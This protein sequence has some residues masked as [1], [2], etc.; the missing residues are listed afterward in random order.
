MLLTLVAFAFALGLLVTFHEWGHYSV[1]RLCG[2]PIVR[3]SVG[4]GPVLLRRV[5]RHG[6]EWALSAIPLGGYVKM[7]DD[8]P[9]GADAAT[10][11]LAF[12]HQPLTRRVAIVLA[13][14]LANLLLAALVYAF[15]G[16]WGTLQ[17]AAVLAAPAA[18]TPAAMAG[19]PA[20][21]ILTSVDGQPVASWTQA[22]WQLME[23]VTV[24]GAILMGIRTPDGS[25]RTVTLQVPAQ[26]ASASGRTDP[27][28]AVGL[29]LASPVPV[30][31]T[32]TPGG[33]AERAGLQPGDEVRAV[34]TIQNPS[35]QRF[36]DVTQ[37]HAGQPLPLTVLR[38]SDL[39][40]L[41]VTPRSET[42]SGGHRIGRIG[43]LVQGRQPQ[44]LVRQGPVDSLV[45]GVRRTADMSLFTL[46]MLGRMLVGEASW[47]AISGPVTIAEYAGQT[48]RVGLVAYL[49]FLALISIS[50]GVL[51]LLPIPMLDGGHLLF[52]VIEALR[53]GRPVPERI[54]DVGLRLGLAAVLGLMVLALF[55]D[56]ERLFS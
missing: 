52:Y 48:A 21:T 10:R 55:N 12:N 8:A 19:L 42:D 47:R 40:S 31:G 5:D 2:V 33:P 51:N 16:M 26:K 25:R 24:G 53:G 17:P 7:L 46:R 13:G 44:V 29:V 14:P 43:T 41:T 30:I 4:F 9:A 22:R 1:A 37:A 20:G 34:G 6:T 32:L 45:T 56:F 15:L 36:V 38:N 54:R 23:P 50:I 39:V 11:R 3:F 28:V 18:N 27:L 35:V 49:D